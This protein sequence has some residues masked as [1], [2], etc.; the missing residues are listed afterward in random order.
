MGLNNDESRS[1][2]AISSQRLRSQRIELSVALPF[3]ISSEMALTVDSGSPPQ[4]H[5]SNTATVASHFVSLSTNTR[6]TDVPRTT[7]QFLENEVR[8]LIGS[9]KIMNMETTIPD[10]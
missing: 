7:Q 8:I 4:S 1:T 3:E 9:V 2:E 10:I 5:A 6:E